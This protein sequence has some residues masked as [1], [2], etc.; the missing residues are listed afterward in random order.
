MFETPKESRRQ[1]LLAGLILLI[2]LVAVAALSAPVVAG[3][4][5]AAVPASAL[6]YVEMSCL[7][8]QLDKI[9]DMGV[10]RDNFAV[11]TQMA[12]GSA[13]DAPNRLVTALA[14][15][16]TDP[17]FRRDLESIAGRRAVLIVLLSPDLRPMPV[18]ALLG[19]GGDDPVRALGSLVEFLDLGR[20]VPVESSLVDRSFMIEDAAGRV[21]LEG[22]V[23][24][25]WVAMG[26]PGTG[27]SVAGF[28]DCLSGG[29]MCPDRSL[30]ELPA[31][32]G[33]A[34]ELP[35]T[36]AVRGFLNTP[37][38]A[39]TIVE[40]GGGEQDHF[41]QWIDGLA[42]A[43]EIGTDRIDSWVAGRF[44]PITENG[45]VAR[46]LASLTPIDHRL[47]ALLPEDSLVTYD[48][49]AS[50]GATLEALRQLL[51]STIP[52]YDSWLRRTLEEFQTATGLDPTMDLLPHLGQGIGVG[53]LP[54]EA[55][56]GGWPLPRPVLLV[57]SSDDAALWRFLTGWLEWKAGAM[58]PRTQGL[59]S[60]TVVTEEVA[61][62]VLLGLQIESLLPLPFPP[63]SP[64]VAVEDGLLIASPIRSAVV[65]TL[66]RLAEEEGVERTPFDAEGIVEVIHLNLPAWPEAWR[67]AESTIGTL[68]A[69]CCA[70]SE[71]MIDVIRALIDLVGRFEP[72]H[73][74]TT[75]TADG[76]FVFH[77]ELRLRG[78]KGAG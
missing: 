60:A 44:L 77:L 5:A 20:F 73:G 28:V 29:E 41:L 53:L 1:T 76:R 15:W 72:A 26:L 67:R 6:L 63:P 32:Q 59:L 58:A 49:G 14:G 65:E 13:S 30:A 19:E 11:I 55:E 24:G 45:T 57:R 70:D 48:L 12:W 68:T 52:A 2:L 21:M 8:E 9:S 43:R 78:V 3:D 75:L 7:V 71:R 38:L 31:F 25:E 50:S 54:P 62:R 40:A 47:S 51:G 39:A 17:A 74:A 46:F 27:A 42:F 34:A 37:Q 22:H 16:R 36:A 10:L 69:R 18:I 56:S 23:S 33:A 4:P 61:G 66:E 64:T 35:A